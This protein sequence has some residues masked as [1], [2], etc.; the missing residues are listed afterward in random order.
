M[1]LKNHYAK[2]RYGVDPL[3]DN[4]TLIAFGINTQVTVKIN[5]IL[6]S[7]FDVEEA[8]LI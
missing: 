7:D 3:I 4:E 5:A 8:D 2:L 6:I 1:Y